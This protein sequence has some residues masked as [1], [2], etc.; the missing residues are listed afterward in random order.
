MSTQQYGNKPGGQN[1]G[2]SQTYGG[3][4]GGNRGSDSGGYRK[5]GSGFDF[6]P[7]NQKI[8]IWVSNEIDKD[9]I[10]FA[11]DFGRFIANNGLTTSQIRIAFGELRKNSVEWFCGREN[12]FFVAEGETGLFRKAA[13]KSRFDRVL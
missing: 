13:P 12:R 9:I 6:N 11:D 3:Q 2:G 10:T 8:K 7:C 4:G 1:P 5:E